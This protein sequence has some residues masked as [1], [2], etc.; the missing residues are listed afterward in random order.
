MRPIKRYIDSAALVANLKTLAE[1]AGCKLEDIMAMVKA[2]AYGHGVANVVPILENEGV[3]YFGVC[4]TEEAQE[5]QTHLLLQDSKLVCIEGFFEA[6]DFESIIANGWVLVIATTEQL[7]FCRSLSLKIAESQCE[8]WLKINTG[9]NRLGIAAESIEQ[10]LADCRTSNFEISRLM[11]HFHSADSAE[12]D[13]CQLQFAKLPQGTGIPLSL[14][15]TAASIHKLF[16]QDQQLHRLG[17]GLYGC[18]PMKDSSLALQE[19]MTLESEILS[20]YKITTGE[21]VG[22]SHTWQAPQNGWLAILTCG[23]AD[24]YPRLLS[25]KAEVYLDGKYA[26]VVGNVSM[27]MCSIFLPRYY[28]AGTKVEMW[29]KHVKVAKLAELIGTI[30][31]E[32]LS[33]V[34]KRVGFRLV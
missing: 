15:N 7:E 23:Y 17:I 22:Y 16:S 20:C 2:D 3:K 6:Q 34:H 29:G 10:V 19:V 25:N 1:Q 27:D 9:M 28:P 12:T 31:Y 11:T 24:G 30:S 8:I 5:V 13:S 21:S 4:S 18:N 33:Q 32:L 26:P 14:N